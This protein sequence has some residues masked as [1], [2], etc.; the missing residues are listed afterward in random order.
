[1]SFLLAIFVPYCTPKTLNT[2]NQTKSLLFFYCHARQWSQVKGYANRYDPWCYSS[3]APRSERDGQGC[4]C[5]RNGPSLMQALNK[6]QRTIKVNESTIRWMITHGYLPRRSDT[7]VT[8]NEYSSRHEALKRTYSPNVRCSQNV[9]ATR[10]AYV[11]INSF[12]PKNDWKRVE[13]LALSQI[14]LP[15]QIVVLSTLK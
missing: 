2:D 4:Y 6:Q 13:K 9:D 11:K 10:A 14:T 3:T 1:M 7:S 8:S 15:L 5:T 12:L